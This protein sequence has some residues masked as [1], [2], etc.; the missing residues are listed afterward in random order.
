M[1][2][3]V[4]FA[5]IKLGMENKKASGLLFYG[6][7]P[8]L[9]KELIYNIVDYSEK[10]KKETG[11]NFYFK[12]T[13]NGTL[14]D[15]EFLKFSRKINMPI[16][17][18]HDGPAQDDCRRLKNGDGTFSLLEEKIPL[19]LKYQPYATAM[20][21]M[22]PSTVHKA[23]STVKFLFDKGFRYITMSLNYSKTALWTKK[24]LTILKGEYKKM[25]QMYIK[26]TKAEEKF[27]LSPFEMKILSH[28][29]GDK[30]NEDRRRMN[31]EQPSVAPDGK[32]Y[33]GSRYVG[34]SA[35]EIGDVFSGI[36]SEKHKTINNLGGIPYTPCKGCALITRCNYAFDN[37]CC[38]AGEIVSEVSPVQCAHERLIT[39]IADKVAEKLY[40]ERNALFIHKHYNEL[41]PVVSLV[42]DKT[43]NE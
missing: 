11:H 39:P 28:L 27:Y 34:Q 4:A 20:S 32:I 43:I 30:Y 18:S 8:L 10:I 31:K 9:D 38:V 29:K 16:G 22:D 40:R 23:A 35:F 19:L 12:M 33:S 25:A 36:D 13:T 2:R 24:H 37:L 26:W 3:E 14:L 42:E 15:E 21:V 17:F 6:G 41:Y 7:E 5:A 1:S